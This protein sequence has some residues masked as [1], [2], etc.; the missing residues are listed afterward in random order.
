MKTTS[1]RTDAHAALS[2]DIGNEILASLVRARSVNPGDTEAEVARVISHWLGPTN[3]EVT[4]STRSP[5]VRRWEPCS[6]AEAAVRG[7]SST[8]YM[9]THPLEALDL[10]AMD[11]FGA[12]VRDGY[13]YARAP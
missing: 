6:A 5:G 8:A 12:P 13:L 3:A 1:A 2:G 10:W 9:D 11:S 7:S 4:G